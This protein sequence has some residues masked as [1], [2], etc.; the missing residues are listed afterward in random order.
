M[1]R[2]FR[3][4]ELREFVVEIKTTGLWHVPVGCETVDVFLVGGGGAGLAGGGGGYTKTFKGD[5]YTPPRQVL[6]PAH[7]KR[8]VTA[9]Q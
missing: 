7:T 6:G 8:V 9:M 1:R 3:K 4:K 2:F 5:G